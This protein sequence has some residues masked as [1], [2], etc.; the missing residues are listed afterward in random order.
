MR[1]SQWQSILSL[2]SWPRYTHKV[3]W[4]P[5]EDLEKCSIPREFP[6]QSLHEGRKVLHLSVHLGPTWLF[7]KLST[8]AL[9]THTP[10]RVSSSSS[11]KPQYSTCL[12]PPAS[13][14]SLPEPTKY[15]VLLYLIT[16]CPSYLT[17]ETASPGGLGPSPLHL[18]GS[19]IVVIQKIWI[20]WNWSG[21]QQNILR[22]N[23]H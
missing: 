7:S 6:Q 16:R 5:R 2:P 21:L 3:Q 8:L 19:P 1:A 11:Q 17:Y 12:W 15:S 18:G 9:H 13:R 14:S 10:H 4:I 22:T 23:L 20:K